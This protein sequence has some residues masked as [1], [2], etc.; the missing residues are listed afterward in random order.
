ML[1]TPASSLVC[2]HDGAAMVVRGNSLVCPRGHS[3]DRAKEGYVNLLPVA[4]KA[5]LDPGDSKDMVAARQRFLNTGAYAPIAAAVADMALSTITA[6]RAQHPENA[7][8]PRP[9]S[10]LDAG[11]GEGY[12]L[13]M[14]A[15]ALASHQSSSA[16]H[17]AGIDVSKWAVRAAAKRTVPASW[18]VAS[19][20]RPPFSPASVDLILCLFG[21]PLWAGFASVQPPG[22]QVLLVDPGPDHLLELRQIIYPEVRISERPPV[23]NA[24]G[25][26]F[27]SES[28]V[29][30]IAHL[31]SPAIIADLLSMTPHAHRASAEGRTALAARA[32]LDV[33]VDVTLRVFTRTAI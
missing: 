5:S 8:R 9:F 21:F 28:P 10:I 12:Y 7:I 11:C 17:L 15:A 2:P 33:T 30:A 14:L 29:R 22:A 23:T 16:V 24:D 26:T 27:A 19:N 32:T 1:V 25:Y 3:F 31:P 6:S 20:R 4:D 18:L 13:Q